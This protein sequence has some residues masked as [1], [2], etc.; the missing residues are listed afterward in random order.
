MSARKPFP[1]RKPAERAILVGVALFGS[2]RFHTEDSLDEM[3]LLAETAGVDV[4]GRVVQARQVPDP[5]TFIG[6]GK[7]K[8]I[9]HRV[10]DSRADVVIFDEELTPAQA[11]NLETE[12][13]RKVMDR[14]GIILDI[15]AGRA[16]SREAMTQVELAQLEYLYPRLTRQWKH[17]SRQEGGIGTR[18][19]GETQLEVDRRLIR[20]KIDHLKQELLRIEKQRAVRRKVRRS[21]KRIALAGY[22]NAGK[23]SLLIALAHAETFVENRLFAT[24][25]ATIRQFQLEDEKALL[26]D[27]VGFIRKLP[28]DL[29]ASFRSTLEETIESDILL[30][31]V[32]ISHPHFERQMETVVQV[33]G[34]LGVED[35]P[36]IRVF[37]KIDL[38]QDRR[39]LAR[40][41]QHYA[42]AVFTSAVR[43][44]GLDSLKAEIA[45]QLKKAEVEDSIEMPAGRFK[46]MAKIHTLASVLETAFHDGMVSIKFRTTPDNAV[47]IRSMVEGDE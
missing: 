7:T 30:H 32:D 16:R 37:N 15:F 33:L 23:T 25:D 34:E 29:V 4:V 42:P 5:K 44:F 24:L 3:A 27:T 47:R 38:V 39:L 14:S 19:P 11:R 46:T 26:I 9:A 31:V 41:K 1:S 12:F 10:R 22:T 2:D 43:G 8:E 45:V 18:G 6:A 35:R 21:F 36:V 28:H 17:L 40:L 20:K 13:G